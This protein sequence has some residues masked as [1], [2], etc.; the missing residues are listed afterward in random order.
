MF[1]SSDRMARLLIMLMPTGHQKRQGG[2]AGRNV[3][4]RGQR[5]WVESL[6]QLCEFEHSHRP[7]SVLFCKMDIMVC[8][9][10]GSL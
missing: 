3:G 10:T 1:S 9:I 8:S 7:F 6:G 5:A 2:V 4:F